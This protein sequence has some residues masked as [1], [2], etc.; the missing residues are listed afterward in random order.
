M[1][2][3][4]TAQ[5]SALSCVLHSEGPSSDE[6]MLFGRFVGEWD[7]HWTGFDDGRQSE[8]SGELTFGWVLDGRAVQD[9]WLVP[10]PRGIPR[11]HGT[12]VRF[13]DPTLGAWR[14]TWVEPVTGRVRKFIGRPDGEDIAL[15]SLDGDPLLR[16]RFTEIGPDSFTW[17]GEYSTDEGRTWRLE[18]RMLAT[19]RP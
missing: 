10:G 5:R 17:L 8:A 13:F 18:E 2:L 9:V 14:S 1:P 15:V 6:L 11:F 16:W 3:T 4:R 19:R 7:L 12:T